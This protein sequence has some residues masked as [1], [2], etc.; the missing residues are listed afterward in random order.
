[1]IETLTELPTNGLTAKMPKSLQ[2]CLLK[3]LST[4]SP[5]VPENIRQDNRRNNKYLT[6]IFEGYLNY[7]LQSVYTGTVR[8][9]SRYVLTATLTNITNYFQEHMSP[10]EPCKS[11]SIL[12]QCIEMV[13]VI[14]FQLTEPSWSPGQL[15]IHP[16]L[17]RPKLVSNTKGMFVGQT[18][19]KRLAL[20]PIPQ[21]L[22]Y[23]DRNYFPFVQRLL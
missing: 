7:L 10:S 3:E 15:V 14:L 6:E 20:L 1:M 21:K 4:T 2:V 19:I 5:K 13:L 17:K 9:W 11:P 12:A 8:P 16:A 22:L 18:A 23:G